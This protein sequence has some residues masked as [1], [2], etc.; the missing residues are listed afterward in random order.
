MAD[1]YSNFQSGPGPN[2]EADSETWA[3]G[4]APS[5]PS[6]LGEPGAG[7]LEQRDD[8]EVAAVLEPCALACILQRGQ[9]L[10]SEDGN[11]PA[12]RLR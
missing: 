6:L 3:C 11:G 5:E 8:R 2:R 4:T 7:V 10:V 9:L 1:S 12:L